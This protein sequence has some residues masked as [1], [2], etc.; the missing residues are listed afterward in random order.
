VKVFTLVE[1]AVICA[2]VACG[3]GLSGVACDKTK[4]ASGE[5]GIGSVAVDLTLPAGA[6]VGKVHYELKGTTLSGT[7]YSA[8]DDVL[9]D[10]AG[11][12]ASVGFGAPA[13]MYSVTM[14]A[15]TSDNRM[16]SGMSDPFGVSANQPTSVTIIIAC[17]AASGPAG[18]V[19]LQGT[20]DNCPMIVAAAASSLV[21]PAEGTIDLSATA[22]DID[23]TDAITYGWKAG[24]GTFDHADGATTKYHCP[25]AVGLQT[26]TLEAADH[27]G[28]PA[29]AEG[30]SDAGAGGGAGAAG[31]ASAGGAGG[32]A[33]GPPRVVNVPNGPVKCTTSAMVVVNCG[34]CGN[35]AVDM[36]AGEQCDP[37]NGTTCDSVC[38]TVA[39]AGGKGGAGNGGAA[40]AGAGGRG[41]AAG[42][43][44]PG[45]NGG[46]AG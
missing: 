4:V 8:K 18:G 22:T 23:P 14:T 11:A 31:G 9:L 12:T 19:N 39:G 10:A 44:A 45:G 35:G 2:V 37:P 5:S 13:G 34:L 29:P 20:L 42:A 7:S 36:M 6:T 32:A 43:G 1:R 28:M 46:G 16:C 25:A 21:V 41:G 26:I 24:G 3:M 17:A 27:D 15:T 33:N 38:Q 40:G 30:S